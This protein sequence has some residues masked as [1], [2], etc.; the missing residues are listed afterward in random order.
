MCHVYVLLSDEGY[1]Y[2]GST[3]DL[4]KRVYQR[5]NQLAG[6]T[7]RGTNW[8]SAYTEE[9]ETYKDARRRELGLKPEL[10]ESF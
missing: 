5:Q 1:R 7:K 10:G 3:T 4:T 2:I 9:F 6:W 8:K